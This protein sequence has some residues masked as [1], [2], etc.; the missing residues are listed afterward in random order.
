MGRVLDPSPPASL[1]EELER[2]AVLGDPDA[3]LPADAEPWHPDD[4]ADGLLPDWYMPAPS[5][6]Q[7]RGWRRKVAWLVVGAALAVVASGLC[8]TYGELVV[9]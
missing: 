6:G 7:L 3:P 1:D 9:A 4:R 2:L 5:G 8:N